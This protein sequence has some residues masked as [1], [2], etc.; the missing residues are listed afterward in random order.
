[1]A[2]PTV[3]RPTKKP[4]VDRAFNSKSVKGSPRPTDRSQTGSA[5][6]MSGPGATQRK[7]LEPQS[8]AATKAKGKA[9]VRDEASPLP[10]SFKIVAGSYE[11]LLYG[12]DGAL[13]P[14]EGE[15]GGYTIAIKPTFAFPAHVSCIKSVAA[16]PHGGKWLAT[17]SADEIIK[18]W[19]LRRKKE[20]GGLMHHEG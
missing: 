11:K 1:M 4:R 5:K 12:L 6:A 15:A 7:P 18:V 3:E 10:R 8:V 19:D 9:K 14:A 16:S 17:G 13:S 2:K 20:I